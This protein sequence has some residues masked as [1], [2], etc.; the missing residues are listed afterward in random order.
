M[1]GFESPHAVDSVR[2]K[3]SP[4]GLLI[5]Q[6]SHKFPGLDPATLDRAVIESKCSQPVAESILHENI[7]PLGERTLSCDMSLSESGDRLKFI[8]TSDLKRKMNVYRL[9]L[10]HPK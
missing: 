4:L 7:Y 6:L 1:S 9:D 10:G 8:R 3:S 5:S 2:L